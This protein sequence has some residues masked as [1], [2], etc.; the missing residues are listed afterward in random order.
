MVTT[1]DKLIRAIGDVGY[2]LVP[3]ER[4]TYSTNITYICNHDH[5][6]S[7]SVSNFLAGK[8]CPTCANSE[9]NNDR[10]VGIDHIRDEMQKELYTLVSSQYVN[11]RTPLTCRCPN[12][13]DWSVRWSNWKTGKRCSIRQCKRMHGLLLA[14]PIALESIV[15]EGYTIVAG[16]DEYV[17]VKSY[18]TLVCPFGHSP[19]QV[20]VYNF[21][22]GRRCPGCACHSSR[23]ERD[24]FAYLST[25]VDDVRSTRILDNKEIDAYSES[26]KFGVEY[27]GLYWHS[28]LGGKD[29]HYH[30]DKLS[31]AQKRGIKLYQFFEDE[32]IH[33]QRI[34][35][36]MIS[37]AIGAPLRRIFA[38]KCSIQQIH[39]D[40]RRRFL[41]ENHLQ[42]DTASSIA[43]G[44]YF[45]DELVQVLA[46]RR[47]KFTKAK[48]V[49]DI[50]R[51]AT[52]I[53]TV[54]VGGLSRLSKHALAWVKKQG[55]HRLY[56]Y[57]DRR[58]SDG[59]SYVKAGFISCGV[60]SP[61]FWYTDFKVRVHR[62]GLRKTTDCPKGMSAHEWRKTQ[63]WHR[64]WDCGQLKFYLE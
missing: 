34:V 52:V 23:G 2:T 26:R 7:M 64:I 59:Q 56:T 50:A 42:G 46:V 9:R 22:N 17:N 55:A 47:I 10:L 16:S 36:A 58:Y 20:Q 19:Y 54:V 44:M 57:A 48:P 27:H 21:R 14:K 60:T 41:D 35:K 15:G 37:H 4:V 61:G 12:G 11:N 5:R 8:R 62:F 3:C 25:L 33:K 51:F 38:R 63:G 49:Y 13:H 18:V 24:L 39:I 45:N 1:A 53:G 31:A 6:H 29:R 30:K 43:W 28:E 40:D 32:W